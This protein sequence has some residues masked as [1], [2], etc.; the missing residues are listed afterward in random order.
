MSGIVK[1]LRVAGVALALALPAAALAAPVQAQAPA[2]AAQ[3]AQSL[4]ALPFG[5]KLDLAKAGDEEAQIAV[6]RAYE[7]GQSV[8][9]N[10]VEAARW[11]QRAGRAGNVE[12]QFR[13]GRLVH[14]GGDGIEKSPAQAARLYQAAARQGHIQA[15]NWL[16]YSYQTG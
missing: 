16:G 15:Q 2:Q 14:E 10:K 4:D 8:A 3:A 6:G 11:Y 9:Q 7:L 13:L 1:L 5:K 12:A